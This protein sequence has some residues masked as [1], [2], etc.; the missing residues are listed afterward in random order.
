VRARKLHP[1]YIIIGTKKA[2]LA[3]A[4]IL[5]LTDIIRFK[6]SGHKCPSSKALQFPE[7]QNCRKCK[8]RSTLW[9]SSYIS[10]HPPPSTAAKVRAASSE[11]ASQPLRLKT[12]SRHSKS[13]QAADPAN[14]ESC[15]HRAFICLNPDICN[16]N[17]PNHSLCS[18]FL[19]PWTFSPSQ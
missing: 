12:Q 4:H 16:L 6:N 1:R 15:S 19:I 18:P 8:S 13:L 3:C 14:L 7:S 5:A 11:L 10:G 9:H 17:L 2:C